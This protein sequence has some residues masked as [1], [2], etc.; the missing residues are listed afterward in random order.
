MANVPQDITDRLKR[1]ERQLKELTSAANKAPALDQIHSGDVVIGEGGQLRAETPDGHRVFSVGQTPRDD[2]GATLARQDGTPAL[3][4]GI[5]RTADDAQMIRVLARDGAAIVM[6]DP[7]AG[8]YLGRPALPIPWQ[9]TP[10]WQTATT[11]D[12]G[13]VSWY[14]ATRVQCPVLHLITETY[15]PTR[16]TATMVLECSTGDGYETWETWTAAGGRD[17]AW[18]THTVTRPMHAISHFTDAVWRIR[19]RVSKGRGR[20]ST[21]VIGSYQRNTLAKDEVPKPARQ[22]AHPSE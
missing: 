5:D 21:H 19:H 2:W 17:G 15:A 12:A 8:D 3:A 13:A 10:G 11:S 6:D 7:W 9:P 18:T 1:V 16:T 20:I 22:E 14:A 4:V